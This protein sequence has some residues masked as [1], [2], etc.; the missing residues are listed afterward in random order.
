[1]DNWITQEN[2]L[3]FIKIYIGPFLYFSL[4]GFVFVDLFYLNGF[5]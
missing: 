2:T 4:Q 5:A 1:M 3:R